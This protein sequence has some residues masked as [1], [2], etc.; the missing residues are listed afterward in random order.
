MAGGWRGQSVTYRCT[1]C[2]TDEHPREA[3]SVPLM[4][5]V[6]AWLME[7]AGRGAEAAAWHKVADNLKRK[8]AS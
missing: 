6:E 8:A 4:A 5:R 1:A 3:H 2:Q 7:A